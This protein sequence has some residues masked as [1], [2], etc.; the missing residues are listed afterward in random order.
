M[1]QDIR[2]IANPYLTPVNASGV[3]LDVL[4][5][6]YATL[7]AST[8]YVY[9]LHYSAGILDAAQLQWDASIVLTSVQIE[10]CCF[11]DGDAPLWSSVAGDWSIENPPGSYVSVVGA[12]A[13]ATSAIVA[14]AGGAAGGCMYNLNSFGSKRC[15]VRVVVGLT[16]GA[17]RVASHGK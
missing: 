9:D 7:L 11:N 14:V 17:L 3:K 13:T 15:R 10:D 5:N 16:G 2:E 6:G 8:T 1:T 4:G 12:G